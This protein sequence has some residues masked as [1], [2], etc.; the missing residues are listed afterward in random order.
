MKRFVV[1]IVLLLF[2]ANHH[3]N[4]SGVIDKIIKEKIIGEKDLNEN[5]IPEKYVW[6]E[7]IL[8]P[9]YFQW[10]LLVYENNSIIFND[11]GIYMMKDK[12]NNHYCSA[13]NCD[14]F[15]FEKNT[16]GVFYIKW[17]SCKKESWIAIHGWNKYKDLSIEISSS[18]SKKTIY[19]ESSLKK[20]LRKQKIIE[21]LIKAY[22]ISFK[23]QDLGFFKNQQIDNSSAPRLE[24]QD[25]N[26]NKILI[27][28]L[29]KQYVVSQKAQGI[30]VIWDSKKQ[31]IISAKLVTIDIDED[32]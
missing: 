30:H 11:V 17:H 1:L 20:Y 6:Q 29:I 18:L 8:F 27:K 14:H 31:K 26:C 15:F 9:D 16:E 19:N 21:K 10:V 25:L 28:Q 5:G 2:F 22:Q 7:K 24:C 23:I 32:L 3:Q 4:V 13:G 12:Y